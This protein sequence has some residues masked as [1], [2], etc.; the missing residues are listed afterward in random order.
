MVAGLLTAINTFSQETFKIDEKIE[1]IKYG[2]N[3][4]LMRPLRELSLCYVFR[5]SSYH[6]G[7]RLTKILSKLKNESEIVNELVNY[8][9]S[10]T[11]E[12]KQRL[13]K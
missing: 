2:E 1:R 5:G 9:T 10:L 6:A 4:I 8:K 13:E 3:T 12:T 11:P 7:K